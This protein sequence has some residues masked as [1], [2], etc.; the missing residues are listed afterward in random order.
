MRA[1]RDQFRAIIIRAV[2]SYHRLTSSPRGWRLRSGR[3]DEGIGP[4][5]FALTG[6]HNC[7]HRDRAG[8]G[9][10]ASLVR[11]DHSARGTGIYVCRQLL[12][13]Y[14]QSAIHGCPSSRRHTPRIQA[15]PGA[16]HRDI[17]KLY[18]GLC[19]DSTSPLLL[20]LHLI[21]SASP[22]PWFLCAG[23]YYQ[24]LSHSSAHLLV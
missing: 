9:G 21:K 8:K 3:S 20:P 2:Y 7:R 18:L 22:R 17:Q 6:T 11:T 5:T 23:F 4:I 16:F 24:V 19:L 14:T 15:V 1:D 10:L 12:T 13:G